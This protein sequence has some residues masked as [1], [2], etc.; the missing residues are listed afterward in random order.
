MLRTRRRPIPSGRI[1]ASRALAVG[2]ALVALALAVMILLAVHLTLLA[3]LGL[4]SYLAA[5]TWLLK[6]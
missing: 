5:Y 6:R 3:A 2:L 4:A 1:E